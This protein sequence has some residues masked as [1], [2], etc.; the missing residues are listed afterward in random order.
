MK[1]IITTIFAVFSLSLMNAQEITDA[2]RFSMDKLNGTARFRAMSGAFG[3]VGGDLSAI[4]VN[5]AG[6][7]IFSASQGTL[8]LANYNVD[9]DA[10]FFGN[11]TN[12]SENTFDLNQLGTVFVFN[13][14]SGRSEWT[15]LAFAI[16]YENASNF[17]DNIFI[18][19]TN[20]NNS[21]DF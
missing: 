21:F 5:P 2:L 18:A 8:S 14:K 3:A 13:E 4:N 11:S 6:S 12:E 19:G 7:A 9:N 17:D 10:N 20:T 16:N 15:R 1:R